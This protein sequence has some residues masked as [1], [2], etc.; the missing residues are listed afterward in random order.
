MVN[1]VKEL[2]DSVTPQMYQQ[3]KKAIELGKWPT[4]GALSAEQRD[5]C[6]QAVIAYEQKHLA[7]E[8]RIGYIPPKKHT[9]CGHSHDEIA[10][11]DVRPLQFSSK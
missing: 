1:N 11:D 10:N 9:H 3:L 6:M 4:G 2:L 8:E 5:L 7:P